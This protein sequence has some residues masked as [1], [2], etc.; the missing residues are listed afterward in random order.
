M[1]WL[2]VQLQVTS[3]TL[4]TVAVGYSPLWLTFSPVVPVDLVVVVVVDQA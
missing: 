2:Q 4:V 1:W 3:Q